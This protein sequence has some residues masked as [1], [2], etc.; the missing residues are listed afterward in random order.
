MSEGH[1]V[2]PVN[3]DFTLW[4]EMLSDWHVGTGLGKHG[5]VDAL[6]DRDE[7]ELPLITAK[8]VR[9]LWRDGAETLAFGLDGGDRQGPWHQFVRTLFGSEPS[10][11]GRTASA[12][13]KRRMWELLLGIF[14][15]DRR[16]QQLLRER[17]VPSRISVRNARL[18][19]PLRSRLRGKQPE[20]RRLRD[21]LTFVKPGVAIEARSG[22]ARDK[23]LRFEEVTRA[24]CM[25]EARGTVDLTGDGDARAAVCAFLRGAA[26][27]V[28]RLGGKRRRGH[29][30][31]RIV[32]SFD[33]AASGYF[34]LD[35]E[36]AWRDMRNEAAEALASISA[37]NRLNRPPVYDGVSTFNEA[38]HETEWTVI[39]LELTLEEPVLL[40][41]AVLGNVVTTLDHIP[42]GQLLPYVTE[43]LGAGARP[44]IA[45]GDIRVLNAYPAIGGTRALPVPLCWEAPKDE[46]P[47]NDSGKFSVRNRLVSQNEKNQYKP[48]RKGYVAL[49]GTG[50]WPFL[51]DVQK[52]VRTHNS[53]EDLLQR[54]TELTGGV[55]S[56]EALAP[57]AVFRSEVWIRT[58][59]GI[60]TT[61]LTCG[62][63][64]LGRAKSGGYGSVTIK[65]GPPGNR[66][67]LTNGNSSDLAVWL[68]SDAILRSSALGGAADLEALAAA[69]EETVGK[70]VLVAR[71]EK[72][73][74]PFAD[75]PSGL[76][77]PAADL[78]HRRLES[79]Q[80]SWGLPRPSL[81]TLQA[82]SVAIFTLNE[83]KQGD[84]ATIIETLEREGIG[85]RRAEGFGQ[86]L[87]NHEL[88]SKPELELQKFELPGA[89]SLAESD[90]EAGSSTSAANSTAALANRDT[91]D[92]VRRFAEAVERAAWRK[93]IA[94]KAEHVASDRDQRKNHL[95]WVGDKPG[96]S[97]LGGLRVVMGRL[98]GKEDEDA[99]KLWICQLNANEQRRKKWPDDAIP[100]LKELLSVESQVWTVLEK[101]SPQWPAE[102]VERHDAVKNRLRLEAIRTFLRIA[103]RCHK[104]QAE[105]GDQASVPADSAVAAAG[106]G[107]SADTDVESPS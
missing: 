16:A 8:T 45:C 46:V 75:N 53:V 84:L 29:G 31:C 12:S 50:S 40:P 5:A 54:P 74:L 76:K 24:D 55:Y 32:L 95:G 72:G 4:I 78:R 86:V 9:G 100:K 14:A 88:L 6:V 103:M 17:P 11:E 92:P 18:V 37:P 52:S 28:E 51:P 97:Q 27:L 59:N 49:T 1:P 56:Y 10:I 93:A 105:A 30:R 69:I 64:L 60:D 19:E 33:A 101:A 91:R 26:G 44:Y 104:R 71:N 66:S 58:S 61:K 2:E 77:Q 21:A 87:I 85:E 34:P 23:F 43:K 67:S 94:E 70:G 98:A 81:T 63:A 83:S 62:A 107:P 39:P 79:W 41:D 102:L 25:L 13:S 68:V 20:K 96:M 106:S 15:P 65:A 36:A 89:Q 82:G 22:K 38:T 48:L 90:T 57:G 73:S 7:D 3:L 99:V 80:R 35:L 42:G 47:A